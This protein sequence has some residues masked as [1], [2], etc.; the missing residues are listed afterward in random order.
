LPRIENAVK[1]IPGRG[2]KVIIVRFPT[3]GKGWQLDEKYA[4]RQKYGD[5]WAA[6]T[7]AV[8]IHFKDYPSWANFPCPDYSHLDYRDSP[9]FT[10][11]LASIIKEK[12]GTHGQRKH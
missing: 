7:S 4:P 12:I 11:A 6:N 1:K 3:V 5:Y 10:R 2:G 8:M 9:A